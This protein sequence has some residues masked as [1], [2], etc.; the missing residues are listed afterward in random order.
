MKG[1]AFATVFLCVLTLAASLGAAPPK[2]GVK[3]DELFRAIYPAAPKSLDPHAAPDPAAWPVIMAAYQRLMTF[4]PGTAEPVP[5]LARQVIV[6][7]NGLTYTF[8]LNEGATFS[9]G[10]ILNSEAAL[11]TFDRLMSSEV[12]QLYY[13]HLYRLEL[14]GPYTFRLILRRPWP[15]FLA[16]LAL[17]Q[18][19]LVSPGLRNKPPDF[20]N[21]R[22]LGSGQYVLYDWKDETIGL[23]TRP[24]LVS[25]P[26][27]AFAMFHY[28]PDA[29][30]RYEKM[31]RHRA[32]L[33]V[34][35]DLSG[36]APLPPN[37]QAQK[38]PGFSVR[39]LAFNT[40]RPYTKMQNTRRAVSFVLKEAFKTRPGHL[41]EAFPPGLFYNAPRRFDSEAP[42][43][44]AADPLAQGRM[45]LNEVGPPA[46]PLTLV[47][48]EGDQALADD[49]ALV[50][51]ALAPYGIVL[52]LVSL[53]G[54]LGRQ[55][56]E[57]GDFDLYLATR[58]ADIPSADMWLGRFMDGASTIDGNPAFFNNE[59]AAAL[60]REIADTV[61]KPDDGPNDRLRVE[62]ERAA[63]LA[64]LADIAATEAP[65]VF[66]YQLETT[67][68]LD[69][70][71]KLWVNNKIVE[72]RPHP[73]WPDIWPIDQ[74]ILRP[75]DFRSGANPTGK[76]PEPEGQKMPSIQSILGGGK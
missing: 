40:Q 17:P 1:P 69:E 33:T 7:P 57:S 65:Y 29:Q 14:V 36:G 46:A 19:S 4:E 68:V 45:I 75:P 72:G 9:D 20:L 54:A 48:R 47:Y 24:D 25:R 13:P 28:E 37:F 21:D 49:A 59:R 63:K 5:A 41:K 18:A 43:I 26:P 52:D 30:K 39:Y 2:D 38:V 76:R 60:V 70:M 3:K 31:I 15:P 51:D 8:V 34:D 74:T 58:T 6:S 61:G 66:L 32:H 23:S 56:V 16:S 62:T 73:A 12:G 44:G 42:A 27:I 67:L 11:F 71:A 53:S 10:S 50:R 64:E 35:P 55:I 22:T